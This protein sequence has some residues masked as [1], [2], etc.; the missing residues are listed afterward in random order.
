MLGLPR[1]PIDLLHPLIYNIEN[2]EYAKQATNELKEALKPQPIMPQLEKDIIEQVAEHKWLKNTETILYHTE[3]LDA[4]VEML[5]K[6]ANTAPSYINKDERPIIALD[7]E[8][9]GLNKG[10]KL[11]QGQIQ[12][13]N[14]I[15]GVCVG[16]NA[17]KGFYIPVNHTEIDKIP[18]Y[19]VKDI[20]AF[21]QRLVDE[22]YVI[23]HN[24][25]F[26]QEVMALNGV[27]FKN[28]AFADTL[29]LS[30][31]MGWKEDYKQLGLKFLS[32]T[33]LERPM[34]EINEITG[35]KGEVRMQTAPARNAYVYG[36]SDAMNT[37]GL[38]NYIVGSKENP[39]KTQSFK[40]KLVHL[41]V[42]STRSM[43]RVGLPFGYDIGIRTTKTLI[44]RMI[45][46]ENIF[47]AK[48][49]KPNIN[50]SSS[51]Q[52]GYHLYSLLIKESA[53]KFN[54]GQEIIKGSKL[55]NDFVKKVKADFNMEVKDSPTKADP[56]KIRVNSGDDVLKAMYAN[57]NKWGFIS[58]ATADE[59]YI[60]C[61]IMSEYRTLANKLKIYIGLV[62]NCY[63]DDLNM[64][65][66]PI[67]LRLLGARTGR[68]S[69]AGS[70][71]GAWDRIEL[72]ELK[73]G[74]VPRF[75]EGKGVCEF[76]AQGLSHESGHW[77]QLK[78]VK[79][80]KQLNPKFKEVSEA[81]D[82]M[83]EA[84]FYDYLTRGG[85]DNDE[86]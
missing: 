35:N 42:S 23:Y 44:R 69:N 86:D 57:L 14:H 41:S 7:L 31:L 33:M 79:N 70:K 18:N 5:Y 61:E 53:D 22:F 45:M 71:D 84:R 20:I 32:K 51:S 80:F 11:I 28:S 17:N 52:L 37:Y 58:E 65:R 15:V 74:I 27:E 50:I 63:N 16:L 68:F 24:A 67:A 46:L 43:F 21:L 77:K 81:L 30:F 39:F 66:A 12:H 1:E 25:V 34:L 6:E 13:F 2:L 60:I 78:K 75:I 36:C 3:S 59:I 76:N 83:V 54:G 49:S 26:D 55:Y 29:L 19:P 85:T 64:N 8:T 40:T 48:V 56:N 82:R 73:K 62:R 47:F 72:D 38:F 4:L 10:I 9:T